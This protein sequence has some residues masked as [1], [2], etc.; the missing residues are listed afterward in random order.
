LR[1]EH[2]KNIKT[3]RPEGFESMT[4]REIHLSDD[5]DYHFGLR[6]LH[7]WKP[8]TEPYISL[9]TL[10]GGKPAPHKG[11]WFNP[12]RIQKHVGSLKDF[13]EEG[14]RHGI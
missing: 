5:Y 2:K 14:L 6:V 11:D 13:I 7:G 9:A 12:E 4:H 3:N 10:K 8:K 1:A